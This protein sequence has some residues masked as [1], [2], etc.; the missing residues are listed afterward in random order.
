LISEMFDLAVSF[1]IFG[2]MARLWPCNA[3]QARFLT[4]EFV[5]NALYSLF[6]ILI[7]GD[8]ATVYIRAGVGVVFQ[9]GAPG[10]TGA[11]LSGYGPVGHLPLVAQAAAI[12]L[13]LDFVQYWLHRLFHGRT[14]WPF[15][16]IHHCAEVVDWSTT[17]RIH[18]ANYV[19]YGAGALAFI[20]LFGFSPAAFAII[21]PFNLV[22]GPLVHAN[23][24]WTFGPFRYVLV[25]PVYHR[26]HHSKDLAARDRNF[27]PTFPIWDL[28]FGTYYMPRDVLPHDY[29][30]EGVPSHF[31]GQLVYPFR[32][33]AERLGLWRKAAAG[34]AV[35]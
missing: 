9:H 30:V 1:L 4:P 13:A 18:P 6:G 5:D 21:A 22:I 33:C 28:M 19:I 31:L 34:G 25:S 15:H 16:A 24:N 26:W 2:I 27:A 12:L 8:L 20:R 7:Y 11:I 29:G 32:V 10:V 17:Y 23:L 14:L 35:A 3:G